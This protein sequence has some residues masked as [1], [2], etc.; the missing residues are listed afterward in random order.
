MMTT[1]KFAVVNSVPKSNYTEFQIKVWNSETGK[2]ELFSDELFPTRIAAKKAVDANES[3]TRVDSFRVAKAL[4]E[5]TSLA[6]AKAA[7]KRYSKKH[8]VD[9]DSFA[10]ALSASLSA[11][12]DADAA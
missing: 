10:A 8:T 2:S 1:Q 4:H 3:L 6:D 7:A 12:V 5:G 11:Y 9:N